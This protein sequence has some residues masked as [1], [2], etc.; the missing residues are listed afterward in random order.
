MAWSKPTRIKP[1]F[2]SEARREDLSGSVPERIDEL[3]NLA[4]VLVYYREGEPVVGFTLLR[5]PHRA[6][7]QVDWSVPN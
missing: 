3:T 6:D 5:V 4:K 7:G 2:V 1:S